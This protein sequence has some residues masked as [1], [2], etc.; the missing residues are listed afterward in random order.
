MSLLLQDFGNVIYNSHNSQPRCSPNT[1]PR[2]SHYPG[3]F[4]AK[5][6]SAGLPAGV[7][8]CDEL[9]VFWQ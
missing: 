1:R 6:N 4:E 5:L 2:K 8:C 3:D 7:L 9:P